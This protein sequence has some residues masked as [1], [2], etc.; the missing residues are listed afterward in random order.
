M[1]SFRTLLAAP[2]LGAQIIRKCPPSWMPY[3]KL[4]RIDLDAGWWI[5]AFPAFWGMALA[6]REGDPLWMVPVWCVLFLLGAIF[7][8]G[9]GST[10]NDMLDENFDRKVS[11]TRSRPLP[12]GM[13]SR[14]QAALFL[15]FQLFVSLCILLTFNTTTIWTAI[16]F[17]PL[18]AFYPLAKRFTWWPQAV[19]GLTFMMGSVIGWTAV[20]GS[21]DLP[22]ILLYAGCVFWPLHFDTIY[23]H[24]D[25]EDDIFAGVKSS[26][27]RLG[28][29]T[30][31]ALLVFDILMVGFLAAAGALAGMGWAFWPVLALVFAHFVWQLWALD[32]NNSERCLYLFSTNWIIGWL[33]LAAIIAG[34]ITA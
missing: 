34:Q 2:P 20:R 3:L 6:L 11:R 19:L 18:V 1:F 4:L 16:A 27:L 17:L 14:K 29:K 32:I 25:R 30:K 22:A 33:V 12:S 10:L 8:H 26:A 21:L 5:P 28:E 23:A 15:L 13:V 24:Q 31:P 7:M 9:A